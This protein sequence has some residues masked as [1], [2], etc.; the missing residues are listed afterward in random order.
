MNEWIQLHF[1][2][3]L[4]TDTCNN[5]K[6][7]FW[8]RMCHITFPFNSFENTNYCYRF[9]S[10]RSGK[11]RS[12]FSDWHRTF[13]PLMSSGPKNKVLLHKLIYSFHLNRVKNQTHIIK[14]KFCGHDLPQSV[15]MFMLRQP[16]L[17]WWQNA[18]WTL[19]EK[20][21]DDLV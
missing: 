15:L 20:K 21:Q 2:A 18:N 10:G 5:L 14:S 1:V 4:K 17:P 19:R 13:S 16:N 11:T 8:E 7:N 6:T 12:T 3:N 9:T